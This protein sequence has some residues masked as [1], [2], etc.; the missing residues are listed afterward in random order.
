MTRWQ[1]KAMIL[2][3]DLAID[4]AEYSWHPVRAGEKRAILRI[5]YE[6]KKDQRYVQIL[7]VV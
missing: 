4:D 7:N 2:E 1:M 3:E 6:D 5:S